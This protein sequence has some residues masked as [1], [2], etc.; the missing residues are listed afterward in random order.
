MPSK[1]ARRRVCLVLWAVMQQAPAWRYVWPV[2]LDSLREN[3]DAIAARHARLERFRQRK[4]A[5]NV[6]LVL[7]EPISIWLV[8]R[9]VWPVSR[10]NIPLAAATRS[11]RSAPIG[12]YNDQSGQAECIAC[13]EGYDSGEG[14]TSCFSVCG[15]GLLVGN[16]ECD[17][18]DTDSDDGCS[19]VCTIEDGYLCPTPGADCVHCMWRFRL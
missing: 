2:R 4:G 18:H 13:D 16:E 11:V 19:S 6:R 9:L 1:R 14:A 8:K 3:W 7:R 5:R 15:D 17:D 12:Y 10:V